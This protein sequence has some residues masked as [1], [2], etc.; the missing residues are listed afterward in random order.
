MAEDPVDATRRTRLAAERT[1]LAWLRGGL[2]ALAVG[3]GAGAVVPDLANGR[4]W[5]F[6]VLGV[7][8]AAL[9]VGLVA[10]GLHR[11]RA[12]ERALDRG[13]YAPLGG[14]AVTALTLAV[15]LLGVAT[16]AV[17]LLEA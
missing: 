17:L 16:V 13:G 4:H 7:G 12:T 9:G 8:F 6:V 1:Y 14:R 15:G 11:H 10:Y 3:I 2:T 5:P